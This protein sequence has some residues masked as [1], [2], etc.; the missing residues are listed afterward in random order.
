[1]TGEPLRRPGHTHHT[2][3]KIRI[4][5]DLH[6]WEMC[7]HVVMNLPRWQGLVLPGQAHQAR[8]EA[9]ER[10]R[11][12]ENHVRPW[13][14]EPLTR[15]LV[16]LITNDHQQDG[17]L[18]NF[19]QQRRSM[20]QRL[21]YRPKR[22]PMRLSYLVC[23]RHGVHHHKLRWPGWWIIVDHSRVIHYNRT[24]VGAKRVSQQHVPPWLDDA[25]VLTQQSLHHVTN[26]SRARHRILKRTPRRVRQLEQDK[27]RLPASPKALQEEDV[28]NSAQANPV[29][30][31]HWKKLWVTVARLRNP[32]THPAFCSRLPTRSIP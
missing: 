12:P 19:S 4:H 14:E 8:A 25:Q 11:T 10:R 31:H 9:Q 30:K 5:A 16:V 29:K 3:L 21:L 26:S 1:M 7:A 18:H 15:L 24:D 28:R 32:I 2:M 20:S 23:K 27:W 6:L 17:D 13:C 22:Q